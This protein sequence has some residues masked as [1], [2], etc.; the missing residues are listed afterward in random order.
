M[1]HFTVTTTLDSAEAAE[2]LAR[3]ALEARVAACAQIEGPIQSMYWW[4]GTLESAREW[5]CT[6]KTA[7]G[8][9][10]ALEALIL[11]THPYETPEIL[12]YPV[13]RGAADYLSWLEAETRTV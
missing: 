2:R 8:R 4:K 13:A 11:R 6:F 3:A 9:Y 5:R 12:A 7:A 1:K 10:E